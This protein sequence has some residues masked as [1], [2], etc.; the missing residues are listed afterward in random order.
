M[1]ARMRFA[2]CALAAIAAFG[3]SCGW[4]AGMPVPDGA[5]TIAI[6]FAQND[7]RLPE[8]EVDLTNALHRAALDRLDLAISDG[9][10]D[11]LLEAR[12][13]DLRRRGGVRS[14]DAQL[15]EAGATFVIEANL[16]DG[17]SGA[18]LRTTTRR[19]T[20]G[21]VVGTAESPATSPDEPG[22]R[23]RLLDNLADGVLLDLFA[24]LS[25]NRAGEP[26]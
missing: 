1:N 2:R 18:V 25:Y 6:G 15:L 19:L 26:G 7:T 10:A 8:V 21:Y 22:A 23:A 12:V 4:H 20:S 14:E 13:V 17:R 16:V 3:A 24:P 5:R 9:P 11:L